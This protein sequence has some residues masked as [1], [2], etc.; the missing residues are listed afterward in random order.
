MCCLD[1]CPP[2]IG[3]GGGSTWPAGLCSAYCD[4]GVVFSRNEVGL[5]NFCLARSKSTRDGGVGRTVSMSR[6]LGL[7]SAYAWR[8]EAAADDDDDDEATSAEFC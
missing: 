7:A 5:S 8:P 6:E 3:N 2:T 4:D 1:A